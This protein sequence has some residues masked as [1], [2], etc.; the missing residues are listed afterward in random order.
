M[1]D[2]KN[3]AS[4]RLCTV[5]NLPSH[6]PDANITESSIRYLIFNAA[7]NGFSKCINRCGRKV[8]IDLDKFEEFLDCACE[9]AGT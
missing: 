6:Y 9:I 4:R 5:K 2:K 8:L 1:S 7:E 3:T